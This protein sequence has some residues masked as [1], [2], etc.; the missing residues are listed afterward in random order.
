MRPSDGKRFENWQIGLIA[1]VLVVVAFYLAFAKSIPFTGDGYTVKAVFEDAQSLPE[2]FFDR[3]LLRRGD[4]R[5]QMIDRCRIPSV[6]LLENLVRRSHCA[7][8][9][10]T[11]DEVV[12]YTSREAV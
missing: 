9:P 3:G 12:R 4:R 1:L 8:L 2:H 5:D 11:A 6:R 10:S 7:G